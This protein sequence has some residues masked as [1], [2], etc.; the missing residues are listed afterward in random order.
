VRGIA[1]GGFRAEELDQYGQ[2]VVDHFSAQA[3][4]SYDQAESLDDVRD[5]VR[6]LLKMGRYQQAYEAYRGGLSRALL[7]YFE[8]HAEILS[9]LQ[10]ESYVRPYE[11]NKAR[12]LLERLGAEIPQLPAY[13][14]AKD[15]KFPWEDEVVA[16]I[17]R[18]RRE[19]G[20]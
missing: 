4:C 19:K 13:D 17:E 14:P 2:K 15:E 18:L 9:L 5:G 12:A 1:A 20:V 6:T 7:V 8:G 11:L 10:P 3:R 16:A